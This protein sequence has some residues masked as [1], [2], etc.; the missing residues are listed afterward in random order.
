LETGYLHVDSSLV[1]CTKSVQSGSKTLRP[2]TL[3]VLQ[4]RIGKILEHIDTGNNFLNR[5]PIVQQLREKMEK[6]DYM[7]LK[8]FCT[9]KEKVTSLKRQLTEC[10]KIF[11]SY[12]SYKGLIIKIYRSSKTK[13]LQNE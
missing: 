1:L 7:Q 11:S 3:K 9:A 8:I 10:E 12:T 4:E 13:L 6:L 5:T 2:E